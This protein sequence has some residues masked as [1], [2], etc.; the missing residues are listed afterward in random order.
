MPP[1]V[2]SGREEDQAARPRCCSADRAPSLT[3]LSNNEPIP[4]RLSPCSLWPFHRS[5][6]VFCMDKSVTAVVI[7]GLAEHKDTLGAPLCPCRHYDDKD[8]EA[9]QGFWNCPCVPMR[10]RKVS[11]STAM[12]ALRLL[13]DDACV[14]AL[15][16]WDNPRHTAAPRRARQLRASHDAT[17]LGNGVRR[18]TL[19]S[20][21]A[22][23]GGDAAFGRAWVST[24]QHR[25]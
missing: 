15:L 16:L 21:G 19:H 3:T 17:P 7:Q 4:A 6:T 5:N 1:G 9:D 14:A 11:A 25:G 22:G 2:S 24:R 10:E 23:G 18:S 13:V 8:A 12:A 20:S